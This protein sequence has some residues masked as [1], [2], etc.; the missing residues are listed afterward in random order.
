MNRA[1]GLQRR[2][3]VSSKACGN[4]AL[5]SR[6]HRRSWGQAKARLDGGEWGQGVD[7]DGGGQGSTDPDCYSLKAQNCS[8]SIHEL[9]DFSALAPASPSTLPTPPH[10]GSSSPALRSS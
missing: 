10:L 5:L 8:P 9:L 6:N 1:S 2:K 3:E 4:P 7:R